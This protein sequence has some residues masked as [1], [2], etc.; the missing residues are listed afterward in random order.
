MTTEYRDFDIKKT[1]YET[2]EFDFNKNPKELCEEIAESMTALF[3]DLTVKAI[4]NRINIFGINVSFDTK[5]GFFKIEGIGV[6]QYE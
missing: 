3:D 5:Q 4:E 1:V 2:R 6:S